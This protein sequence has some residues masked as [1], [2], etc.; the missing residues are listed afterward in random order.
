MRRQVRET[1]EVDPYGAL[2]DELVY[3]FKVGQPWSE[4]EWSLRI[5][6]CGATLPSVVRFEVPQAPPLQT[7]ELS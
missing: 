1:G 4:Q 6:R 3:A 2:L 7:S 5:T